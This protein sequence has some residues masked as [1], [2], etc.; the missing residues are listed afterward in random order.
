MPDL[1]FSFAYLAMLKWSEIMVNI[2]KKVHLVYLVSQQPWP[3]TALHLPW[4]TADGVFWSPT[5]PYSHFYHF[6]RSDLFCVLCWFGWVNSDALRLRWEELWLSWVSEI[7]SFLSS[8]QL[9]FGV[10]TWFCDVEI[11]VRASEAAFRRQN[12]FFREFSA[13]TNAQATAVLPCYLYLSQKTSKEYESCCFALAVWVVKH[14]DTDT[15]CYVWT[16]PS[17]QIDTF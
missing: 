16:V 6:D 10:L 11:S 2:F 1:Q 7:W 12:W 8:S 5:R 13:A 15:R 9:E 4:R 3:N 14:R 17:W